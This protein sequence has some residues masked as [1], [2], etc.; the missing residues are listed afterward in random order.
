MTARQKKAV[1][2]GVGGAAG[3]VAGIVMYLTTA[4]PD[5]LGVAFSIVGLVGGAL[6]FSVALPNTE[7]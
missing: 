2:I 1:G 5:W 4:T 6:G 7:D 3:I